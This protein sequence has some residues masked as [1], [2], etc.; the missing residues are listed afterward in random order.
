MGEEHAEKLAHMNLHLMVYPNLILHTNYCHI[1]VVRP[2][3]VDH[4]E[5]NTYPCKLEGAGDKLNEKLINAT[6]VHV[7]PAGRVQVD[8]L[9]VFGRVTAGMRANPNTGCASTCG[10]RI[11]T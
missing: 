4:T 11:S 8:D 3:A 6:A 7:S 9:E 2:M 10:D 5:I 1:R